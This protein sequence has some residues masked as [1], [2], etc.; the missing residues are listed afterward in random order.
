MKNKEIKKYYIGLDVGTN[1]VGYAVTDENYNL[2]KFHGEPM[3]G[4]H[5]FDAGE[6]SKKRRD[7]RSA[8]R[9]LNRR[10]Q[11]VQLVNEL[12]AAEIAKID[13]DYFKRREES[14][15]IREDGKNTHLFSCLE[16][17]KE[18]YKKYPTVFH[19]LSDLENS[20]E[21]HDVRLV[22]IACA[23]LVAHR[24][25]F[26]SEVDKDNIETVKDF[27]SVW[28]SFRNSLDELYGIELPNDIR[29]TFKS[30]LCRKGTITE[31][32]KLLNSEL[33]RFFGKSG[34]EI[35]LP[36]AKEVCSLLCGGKC[37]VSS[38]FPESE[39][40]DDLCL[41]SD[42]DALADVISQLDDVQAELIQKMKT[43]YDWSV[44]VHILGDS[45]TISESKIK[46]Y[47]QHREDLA[48]LKSLVRKYAPKE[49]NRFFR[50]GEKSLY[51]QY[52]AKRTENELRKETE[53]IIPES[54][55]ENYAEM[56]TRIKDGTFLPRQHETDNRVIPYQLYYH[57]L[58]LLLAKA[59]IYLPFLSEKD[60]DGLTA[61][62]KIKSIF[63]FRIP[64]FVGPLNKSSQF[65]WLERKA[66]GKIY[67]WNFESI[68]D[69][70]KSEEAFIK[71]M[72]NT[73]TYLPGEKV[74]PKNSL[75]YAAFEVLNE[76]NCIKVD[77][78]PLP[79]EIK[80]GLYSDVFL[81]RDK[82]TRKSIDGY[83]TSHN[84][85]GEITGIDSTVKSSL[86]PFRKFDRLLKNEILTEKDVEEIINR[87]AY[88]EDKGYFKQWLKTNFSILN[89]DDVKY[90][91]GLNLKGFG[92]LSRKFLC[93]RSDENDSDILD[94]CCK[95]TGEYFNSILTA[96]W[97]TNCNL[98]QILSDKF[99]FIDSIKKFSEQYYSDKKMNLAERLDGMYVS[100]AVKR[101]IIRTLD[102]VND[103]QKVM[104]CKPEKV[105]VEMARGEEPEKK[106]T[107][108]R[109]DRL[110]DL[111]KKINTEE[112][113]EF[114]KQLDDM[115]ENA[116]NRLQ[117]RALFLYYTQLGKCMYSGTPLT[118]SMLNDKKYCN[119]DHIY[120]QKYVKDDSLI[121]NEVLVLSTE[122]GKKQDDFPV[123]PDIQQR[124]HSY[125][126]HLKN[127]GLISEEKFRRLTR[128]TGFTEEEKLNFINRQLVETRQSTKVLTQLFDV[129]FGT[130]TTVFVKAGLVSDFRHE[131]DLPKSR[132]LNDLHHAKDAYLNI[133]AGNVYDCKFNRQYFNVNQ[134]YTVNI[135][136]LFTHSVYSGNTC[137]WNGASDL[138]KVKEIA[139]KNC[140]H[141]TKYQFIR[142]SGQNGGFFDQNPVSKSENLVPL[143]KGLNTE[144]YGGYNKPTS[145]FW[146]LVK[147]SA[148][149]KSDIMFVPV[150]LLYKN[151][152]SDKYIR[153]QIENICNK[154]ID[155][156]QV[157]LNGRKIKV[158][159]V[160]S[161][162]GLRL[163]LAGKNSCG[164]Q[165]G[166]TVL[167]PLIFDRETSAYIK[168]LESFSA[169]SEKNKY[170]HVDSEF[171]GITA[172][173]N[174]NLYRGYCS[175]L[176][177]PPFN[178]RPSNP[179]ST[180]LN[181]EEKFIRL[182]LDE[183]V[184]TLT[185]VHSLFRENGVADLSSLGGKKQA[186]ITALS[187][188]LS[189]WRKNYSD[190]RIIDTSAS[191]LF[192][193]V[194]ENLFDLL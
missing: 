90:I 44:L 150:D 12:F 50:H 86:R 110:R 167:N 93:G 65:A 83:F 116:N 104:G 45:R 156:F 178:K 134:D 152:L 160:I 68:V 126:E 39:C 30:I 189:N 73:C 123:S 133:A 188:V 79:V 95:E 166:V 132:T 36:K 35:I 149:K 151:N 176:S 1:S 21:P 119:I 111:Y 144:L 57:E 106:R 99:T 85:S 69:F 193:K 175:K 17:E 22:H 137:V 109:L 117:S 154:Q 8:R 20:S 28:N 27:T 67:P 33:S 5:L 76:I 55:R 31:K 114:Q 101:P 112:S 13:P 40:T 145:A 155:S 191:G 15:L 19:L 77:G 64:Y 63:C 120:P 37:K 97:K 14:R 41:G 29:E 122:N 130:G 153:S 148:G 143:K 187:S 108:S 62:D 70:E 185:E 88:S 157:L 163:L 115:G 125:W 89:E 58:S 177:N 103:I 6:T 98:M 66:E 162:D 129:K 173:K 18:Y 46:S 80:Q 158:N 183:Q 159:S 165:I 53:K 121:N 179:I 47:N 16:E 24:G 161:A 56:L 170:L 11:R 105:F 141:I 9:R 61:S 78:Q 42:D 184:K 48:A 102:I 94:G 60:I 107:V 182:T 75:C 25:H 52:L 171:D 91:A 100:N 34:E 131:F 194:S 136:P 140:I 2:C 174:L 124:M 169:K 4:V 147:Y 81:K 146:V 54:E 92:R 181:G 82:V 172:E 96:M 180:L 74:L 84:L 142:T 3:W 59:E 49:F 7:A 186:G 138:G 164:R 127:N 43:V 118:L 32:S 10:Q 168:R 72:T 192:E 139:Q 128:K 38:V 113:R 87:A 135:V 23:W 51:E 190:V 26:F 71:R